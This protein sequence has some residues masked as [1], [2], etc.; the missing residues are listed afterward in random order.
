MLPLA[1]LKTTPSNVKVPFIRNNYETI[2]EGDTLFSVCYPLEHADS[3]Q[4]IIKEAKVIKVFKDPKTK[5]SKLE[6][7]D[8]TNNGNSGGPLLDKNLNL[9]GVVAA[10]HRY[11]RPNHSKITT[12][13]VA[14]AIGVEGLQK[15]LKLHNIAFASSPSYDMYTNYAVDGRVKNYV[16]NIHCIR[17][18]N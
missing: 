8:N 12:R 3:G 7:T 15:F 1:L 14:V 5:F 18:A 4:Y 16:V 10:K 6:F 9:V 13:E 2:N 17:V 11:Y